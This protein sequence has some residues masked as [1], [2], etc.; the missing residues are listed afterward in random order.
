MVCGT[1]VIIIIINNNYYYRGRDYAAVVELGAKI[2]V[3]I[4][5]RDADKSDA[6][7]YLWGVTKFGVEPE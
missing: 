1:G 3:I 5:E 6:K 2:G 4:R 7:V